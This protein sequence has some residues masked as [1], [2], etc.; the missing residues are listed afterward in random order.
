[1]S[2][3]A[4]MSSF[5]L[6]RS[7]Q[8]FRLIRTCLTIE[9]SVSGRTHAHI[10]VQHIPTRPTIATRDITALIDVYKI[11][12]ICRE[13]AHRLSVLRDTDTLLTHPNTSF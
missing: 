12:A 13:A 3:L 5:L 10:S 9:A 1:M 2:F 6:C 11:T 4:G 7:K 8:M